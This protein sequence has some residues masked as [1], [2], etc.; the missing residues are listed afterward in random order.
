V[1][2]HQV[3][4]IELTAQNQSVVAS[5]PVGMGR[6]A[7]CRSEVMNVYTAEE[8]AGQLKVEY[9]TVLRLIQ[10]GLLKTLPG[11]RHKRIT[12]AELNRY[13]GVQDILTAA[14]RS[15]RPS[16]GAG[17]NHGQIVVIPTAKVVATSIASVK[18]KKQYAVKSNHHQ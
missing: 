17:V 2:S 9:K 18:P 13:L 10:R 8:V 3:S 5:C 15:P 7:K 14:G 16:S 6:Q 1:F 4:F 11:I 12:E